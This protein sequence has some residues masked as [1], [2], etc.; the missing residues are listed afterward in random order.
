MG[1]SMQD[2]DSSY[3]VL[4]RRI[5]AVCEACGEF[6]EYWGFKSI[7]GKV[8]A[9]LALSKNPLSQSHLAKSLGV[10]RALINMAIADLQRYGLVKAVDERHH[11]PY[12][13]VLDV[14]PIIT[15]VLRNR[16]WLLLEKARLTLEAALMSAEHV[17]QHQDCHTNDQEHHKSIEQFNIERL[18]QLLHMTEWSQNILKIL[19]NTHL[20][21]QKEKWGPWLERALKLSSKLKSIV[22]H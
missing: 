12:Q 4:T 3:D 8:W 15:D 13:A 17:K 20:P 9:Y 7:H 16:E 11:A 2:F 21:Q 6:I 18:E 5:L 14:W 19:I 22:N 1:S 10:S